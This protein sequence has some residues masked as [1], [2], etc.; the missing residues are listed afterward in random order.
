MQQIL[1]FREYIRC[2]LF[3]FIAPFISS[4]DYTDKFKNYLLYLIIEA[5]M[6]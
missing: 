4:L 6:Q 5:V 1:Y 3:S 2:I